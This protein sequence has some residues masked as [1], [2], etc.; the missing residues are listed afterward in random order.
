MGGHLHQ[1]VKSRGITETVM[2][3]LEQLVLT[4]LEPGADLPGESELASQFGVSRLTLREAI[5]ALQARGLVEIRRGRRPAVA[6]PN[7]RPIGDFFTT[8]I[9][10]SCST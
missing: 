3:K 10:A 5:K 7:A 9:P 1:G 2:E 6:F 4:E 8:V